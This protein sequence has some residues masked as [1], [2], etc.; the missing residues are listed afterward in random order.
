MDGDLNAPLSI[1]LNADMGE[2]FGPYAFGADGELLHCVS[3][4]NI[5]CGFH[6]GDPATMRRTVRLALEHGAAIGAHPGLPDRLGFGRR[7]ME[8]TPEEAYE[9]VLYQIGALDAFV[10]AEGGCMTHVKPHGALYNM[11][12]RY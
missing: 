2:G 7:A 4:V 10:R 5:A 3:S 6:A 8:I 11:A 12:A 1:D 9:T